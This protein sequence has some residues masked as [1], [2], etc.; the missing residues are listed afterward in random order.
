MAALP[1]LGDAPALA[2]A[3]VRAG[4]TRLLDNRWV[5]AP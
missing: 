3:A 4:T 2:L 5:V 1:R